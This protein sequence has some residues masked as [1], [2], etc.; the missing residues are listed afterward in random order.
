[1]EL[2]CSCHYFQINELDKYALG[3]TMDSVLP[4]C[5][6]GT[7]CLVISVTL[8]LIIARGWNLFGS[9]DPTPA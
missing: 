7:P 9:W 2:I 6:T 8:K 5:G 1:M 3:S 4:L